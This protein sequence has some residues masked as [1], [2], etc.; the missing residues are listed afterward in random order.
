MALGT[1]IKAALFADHD[2]RRQRGARAPV[3]DHAALGRVLACLGQSRLGES[4]QQL[5]HASKSGT[6][7]I[8]DDVPKAIEQACEDIMVMRLLL[9]RAV[10]FQM[11][12]DKELP[13]SVSDLFAD[14]ARV[15]GDTS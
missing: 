2:D 4:M 15:D 3:K 14:A 9:M 10:G 12:D 1:Y 8:D 13:Q 5:S 7:Y 11:P 6:L